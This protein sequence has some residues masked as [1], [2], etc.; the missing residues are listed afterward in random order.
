MSVVDCSSLTSP[1]NGEVSLTTTTFE[2]V[3]M[4]TCEEGY[5]LM[6]SPMRECQADGNWTQQDPL[7]ES[8][9]LKIDNFIMLCRLY[10]KNSS[11]SSTSIKHTLMYHRKSVLFKHCNGVEHANIY[12]GAGKLAKLST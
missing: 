9:F 5:L 8:K 1:S 12:C 3:A 7:C 2:S 10:S 4:Y 6:G 11:H